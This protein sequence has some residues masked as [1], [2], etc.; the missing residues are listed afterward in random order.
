MQA[1]L[2]SYYIL[3]R[4]LLHNQVVPSEAFECGFL[5]GLTVVRMGD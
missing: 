1:F 3:V 5:E 2:F 4:E